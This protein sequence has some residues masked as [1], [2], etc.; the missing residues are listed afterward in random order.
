M[1][2]CLVGRLCRANRLYLLFHSVRQLH[3]SFMKAFLL[4]VQAVLDALSSN[5]NSKRKPTKSNQGYLLPSSPF[6]QKEVVDALS[7]EL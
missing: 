1:F 2:G 5:T 6:V 4:K 7:I 3:H